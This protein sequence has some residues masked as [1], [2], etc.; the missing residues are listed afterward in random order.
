M[1]AAGNG[2]LDKELA[3]SSARSGGQETAV[4][5]RSGR[6]QQPHGTGG[7]ALRDVHDAASPHRGATAT[8]HDPVGVA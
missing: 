6:A 8:R 1:R 7:T 4:C 2:E 5:K 3:H